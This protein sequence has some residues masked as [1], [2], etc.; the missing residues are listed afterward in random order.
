SGDTGFFYYSGH[1]VQYQGRNYLIPVGAIP[2][3][4]APGHLKYKSVRADY[5][6][7]SMAHARN[8]M[9]II[10]LDACRN[11]PFK[12]LFK[13]DSD[14]GLAVTATPSGSLVAYATRAGGKALDGAGRNSPYVK[15]LTR[16]M[17]KPGVK[18]LDMFTNVRR[19]VRKE[20]RRQGFD[21]AP[22]FYSELDDSDF[23][24]I[25]PCGKP[26]PPRPPLLPKQAVF[27]VRSNVYDDQVW[28]DEEF[29]GA[30]PVR[31]KLPL[32]W[33]PVR[34][35]KEG[36]VTAD[37][38][39]VFEQTVN[40]QKDYTLRVEFQ[41][42]PAAPVY[43]PAPV[44]PVSPPAPPV[45]VPQSGVFRDRLADGSSGP[46]MVWIPAGKFMMGDIQGGGGSDE[47]PVH[48]VSVA[49]F[50]MGK[51]EVTNAQFVKFLNAT[52]RRGSKKQQWFG[53]KQEDSNSHITGSTGRFRTESGYENHPVIEVSWYGALAYAEWLNGQ[54]DEHYRLPTEAEW[55]YA[56]RA[57]TRTKYWQ[58]NSIG[59][60]KAN[61]YKDYCGDRFDRTSPIGSFAANPFG[62]HDTAGN[63]WEWTCSE[64]KDKYQGNEKR[65]VGKNRASLPVLRGGS[66]SGE[67]RWARAANR[68]GFKP[69][70]RNFD[71]GFRLAR[72]Y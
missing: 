36:H 47:Q 42:A 11:N 70:G 2:S 29:Q 58:G 66:W 57:G 48:Q 21:Q 69:G 43:T 5:V 61:C 71:I 64:Y 12:S 40:L 27:T 46:E 72:I 52:G 30:T 7:D 33:H 16:E 26:P 6:L 56:A 67:P 9:N 53:T 32:G 31:K 38:K 28:I 60:N 68:N 50:A 10:I 17:L 4:S 15:H 39:R 8:A 65:C 44:Q 1:G 19:A 55:E 41:P 25:G 3:I 59:S 24:F 34:V 35:E 49:R 51:Y 22:A 63:V 23:C 18:I 13:G 20:A 45:S 14:Q 37:G 62:L 54:T